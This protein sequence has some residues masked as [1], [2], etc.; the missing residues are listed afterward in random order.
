[1]WHNIHVLFFLIHVFVRVLFYSH[2]IVRMVEIFLIII[3][4]VR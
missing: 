1:M 4:D 3:I 2:L